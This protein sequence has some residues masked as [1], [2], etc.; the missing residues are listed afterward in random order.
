MTN[1]FYFFT[2]QT[3]ETTQWSPLLNRGHVSVL[4]PSFLLSAHS[5]NTHRHTLT[6]VLCMCVCE[7]LLSVLW[8][9]QETWRSGRE[10][11]SERG[12]WGG[13]GFRN[14]F[15]AVH[16]LCLDISQKISAFSFFFKVF[17]QRQQSSPNC[18]ECRSKTACT[19]NKHFNFQSCRTLPCP[20]SQSVV[21]PD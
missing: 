14:I 19:H 18:F 17:F 15:S 9:W 10:E 3:M 7:S 2:V 16:R 5:F 13:S 20:P 11:E 12:S 8:V 4:I 6:Q 1:G 21:E